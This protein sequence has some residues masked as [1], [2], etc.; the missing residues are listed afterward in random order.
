MT[1]GHRL[2]VIRQGCIE[3][4]ETPERIYDSPINR[5]VAEFIGSPSMN[6]LTGTWG[7]HGPTAMLEV[8]SGR[9][10]LAA[11]GEHVCP[12]KSGTSVLLG[13]RPEDIRLID[14]PGEVSVR[15]VPLRLEPLGHEGLLYLDL[16]GNQVICRTA[17]WRRY[18]DAG[19][20]YLEIPL[21][22]V[23]LFSPSDESVLW[24]GKAWTRALQG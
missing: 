20:V 4:V 1:L 14:T 17:D 18:R 11:P 8:A 19:Q 21:S 13:I 16:F 2:G 15:A 24:S 3:Q 9:I 6:F 22:A 12:L 10:P 5:F 23:H 7:V